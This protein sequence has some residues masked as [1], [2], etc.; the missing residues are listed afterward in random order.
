MHTVPRSKLGGGG[1]V[2]YM[3]NKVVIHTHLIKTSYDTYMWFKIDSVSLQRDKDMFLSFCYI[4]PSNS[5][6]YDV[7]DVNI[8]DEIENDIAH[9]ATEGTVA[10]FGDMN[11][12][13]SCEI[14]MIENDKLSTETIDLISSFIEY[15]SEFD[16]TLPLRHSEDHDKNGNGSK[17]LNLCRTSG[18][19][20][21]NGRTRS[22][23][24]GA[25]TFFNSRGM[26]VIDY[27]IVNIEAWNNVY[28][29]QVDLFNDFSDHAPIVLK[30]Y[31][32]KAIN[33]VP[34]VSS[35]DKIHI[36][37]DRV[38]WNNEC[39]E[40]M[41]EKLA[42]CLTDIEQAISNIEVDD[43]SSIDGAVNDITGIIKGQVS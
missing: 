14:E 11:F 6:Y 35:S 12:R 5:R 43:K 39:L 27:C 30:L 41:R 2:V 4:P 34:C 33:A 32:S 37:I 17:L 36:T 16:M 21:L 8:F 9:Y 15:D 28:D 29:F 25:C 19:I 22:D 18:L 3:K 20:I 1:L 24:Q 42:C 10:L 13:T 26:S 23:A 40:S 31:T 38:A 7:Y